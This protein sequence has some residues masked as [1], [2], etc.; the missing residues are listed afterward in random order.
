MGRFL[1]TKPRPAT[2]GV[3]VPQ[4]VVLP[5]PIGVG[6]P[7]P[8][9]RIKPAAPQ[10]A[11]SAETN[12]LRKLGLYAGLGLVF[13]M[14]GTVPEVL[15]FYTGMSN[16]FLYIAAV[17]AILGAILAGG[18]GRTLRSRAGFLYVAFFLW[19][20]PATF[21]SS[22]LGGSLGRL[23]DVARIDLPLL[24]VIAGLAVNWREV[25]LIIYT[26]AGAAV[27]N[28]VTARLL[29]Q[30]QNGRFS[31][32]GVGS[33]GDANDFSSHLLLVLPFLLFLTLDR[34]TNVAIRFVMPVLIAYGLW[35]I[36]GTASRGALLGVLTALLFCLWRVSMMQ[37]VLLFIATIL[38]AAVAVAVLPGSTLNRLGSLVGQTGDYAEEAGESADARG[39]LFRQSV[40]F[41]VEHPIFGVGPDQFSNFEGKTR[42]AAGE[43]G[44]W[45]GTHNAWTQVSS[46]CGLPAL[47][48]L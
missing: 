44:S 26:I 6:T 21:F 25:R 32:E 1:S 17:P 7:A 29:L 41:T 31:L 2:V 8:A 20:I 15:A 37:K 42:V 33:I 30:S 12:P 46:E 23:K 3:N 34:K 36:L 43:V 38:I 11:D 19:M 39:Y 28:L 40:T 48:F 16:Y 10:L 14:V 27:F 24:F 35:L 9:P 22:W 18:V 13:L 47:I 4:A 5:R 45:H